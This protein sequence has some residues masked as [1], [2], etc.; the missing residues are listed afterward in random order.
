MYRPRT[1]GWRPA[2][3]APRAEV[4]RRRQPSENVSAR[5]P[6]PRFN[7][8][9]ERSTKLQNLSIR[10]TS[11]IKLQAAPRLLENWSLEVPWDLVIGICCFIKVDA[12]R[13]L[14]SYRRTSRTYRHYP[15]RK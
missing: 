2:L 11:I 4:R 6:R 10:E 3:R 8:E 14:G 9:P 5:P 12:R 1:L 15:R 7:H 13:V